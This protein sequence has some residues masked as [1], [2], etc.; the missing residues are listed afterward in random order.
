VA[1]IPP[2]LVAILSK[3]DATLPV[4]IVVAIGW[5]V[6]MNGLQPRIMSTSLRIHPLV[7]LGSVLVGLKV[8][9]IPGAIFGIP[10][11]AVVSALF[12]HFLSRSRQTG[13]VAARA[14]ARVVEREGRAVRQPREP[15]P[16]TD[17]DVEGAPDD[18]PDSAVEAVS[19]VIGDATGTNATK[20]A[21]P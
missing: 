10:I 7:V 18:A 19:D 16:M 12:L 13:P 6:V 20:P 2:I 11:A 15:N 4:G 14:A 21:E 17:R 1:W 8:A 5:L 9:G 3:P